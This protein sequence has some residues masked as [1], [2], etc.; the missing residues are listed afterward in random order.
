MMLLMSS[1]RLLLILVAHLKYILIPISEFARCMQGC[2]N[3][4]PTTRHFDLF[5]SLLSCSPYT[6]YTVQFQFTR[7]SLDLSDNVLH[8]WLFPHHWMYACM[9]AC[10]LYMYEQD[11]RLYR[12]IFI[13]HE[14]IG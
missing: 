3:I 6:S 11:L 8:E 4:E 10:T 12:E 9:Q 1:L 2:G 13:D 7:H 14:Y 5:S